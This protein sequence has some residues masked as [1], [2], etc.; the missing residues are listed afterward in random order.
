VNFAT[1]VTA[2]ALPTIEPIFLKLLEKAFSVLFKVFD[3][4]LL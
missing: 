2:K 1:A 3:M 4:F